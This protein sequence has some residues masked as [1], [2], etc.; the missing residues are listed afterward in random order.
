MSD[1]RKRQKELKSFY[2]ELIRDDEY[3]SLDIMI[4]I[5]LHSIRSVEV[6]FNGG[7]GENPIGNVLVGF[8]TA[9]PQD[10]IYLRYE[11][12]GRIEIQ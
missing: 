1:Y 4:H 6:A 5:I 12:I 10:W 9:L 3:D 7:G 11:D 2:R 8:Y